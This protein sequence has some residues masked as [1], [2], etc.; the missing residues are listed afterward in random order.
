LRWAVL[1]GTPF[2]GRRP[3]CRHPRQTKTCQHFQ[4]DQGSISEPHT[5]MIYK[6]L[7]LLLKASSLRS[8]FFSMPMQGS[9]SEPPAPMICRCLALPLMANNLRSRSLLL[10][11]V[12]MTRR[13]TSSRLSASGPVRVYL[14]DGGDAGHVIAAFLVTESKQTSAVKLHQP[15]KIP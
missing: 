14:S 3:R 11:M 4:S 1:A 2:G 6:S 5:P 12:A 7:P 13:G 8:P 15:K 10:P 9:I